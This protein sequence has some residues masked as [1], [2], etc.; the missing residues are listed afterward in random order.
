MR[1]ANVD[2]EERR[3]IAVLPVNL[4]EGGNLPPEGWSGVAAKDE[5]DRQPPS[6]RRELHLAAGL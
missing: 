4:V 5:H 3:A 1:L 6:K 2:D